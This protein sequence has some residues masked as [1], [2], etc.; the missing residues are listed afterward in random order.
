[1]N[2]LLDTCAVLALAAGELPQR[3]TAALRVAPEAMVS[4]VSAWELAIKVSAGKIEL[5]ADP[6]SWFVDFLDHFDLR[7]VPVDAA[8]ACAAC[9]LPPIH[10]DPF[11]RMIVA[12]AQAHGLAVLTSDENIGRY[13]GVRT[14]W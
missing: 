11:D 4:S 7:E 8:L 2:V 14:L 5:N 9:T 10:R 1:M 13:S 12:L 6:A 3:A